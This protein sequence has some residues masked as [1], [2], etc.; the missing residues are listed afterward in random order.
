MKLPSPP[1]DIIFIRGTPFRNGENT[2]LFVNDQELLSTLVNEQF[3]S[4][5]SGYTWG[6][7]GSGPSCTA[8]AISYSIFGEKYLALYMASLIEKNYVL[9]WPNDEPFSDQ[10]NLINFWIDHADAIEQANKK[11]NKSRKI[12]EKIAASTALLHLTLEDQPKQLRLEDAPTTRCYGISADTYWITFPIDSFFITSGRCRV[13]FYGSSQ[14]LILTDIREGGIQVHFE[15]VIKVVMNMLNLNP[16]QIEVIQR[17][18][19]DATQIHR[20]SAVYYMGR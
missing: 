9:T 19:W 5:C 16:L 1:F 12:D 6:Y 11:A 8:Q 20:V 13:D 4:Y 15:T 7:E 3:G 2:H 17:Y 10:I 14:L 18:D